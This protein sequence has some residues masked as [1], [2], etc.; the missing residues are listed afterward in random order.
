MR[1][2]SS[3]YRCPQ[4][5]NRDVIRGGLVDRMGHA[6]RVECDRTCGENSG[7]PGRVGEVAFMQCYAGL[8]VRKM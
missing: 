1:V 2:R 5:G 3:S 6:P 4:C 8:T 7:K